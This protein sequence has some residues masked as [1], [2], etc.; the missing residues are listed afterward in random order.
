M[1]IKAILADDQS[2]DHVIFWTVAHQF[3]PVQC[4][5]LTPQAVQHPYYAKTLFKEVESLRHL[6]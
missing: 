2:V 1:P 3:D 4:Y 6:V 5:L